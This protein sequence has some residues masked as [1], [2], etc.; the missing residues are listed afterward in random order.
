MARTSDTRKNVRVI[1]SQLSEKGVPLSS[2]GI[3]EV[4]GGGS[5]ST[6]TDELRRIQAEALLAETRGAVS[7]APVDTRPHP[8]SDSLTE[9]TDPGITR[10]LVAM[11]EDI[12]HLTSELTNIREELSNIRKSNEEQLALAYTRYEAV[13]R[14]ALMQVEAA[15]RDSIG[16]R[17]GL[18]N[19]KMDGQ[20]REDAY[21]GK[22]QA[23]RD[24]NAGLKAKLELL[25]ELLVQSQAKGDR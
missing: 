6:I 7:W 2:R 11:S 16:L 9:E 3:R 24:E 20:L 19:A 4:L 12:A 10:A 17:E 13:Q 18:G 1:A 22:A 25:E 15:R 21:R 5:L 23:L 14:H 8:F